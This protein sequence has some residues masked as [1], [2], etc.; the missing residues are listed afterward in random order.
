LL[1]GTCYLAFAGGLVGQCYL[2]HVTCDGT[3]AI[4][5]FGSNTAGNW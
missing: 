2:L 3:H 4:A 5:G 1:N